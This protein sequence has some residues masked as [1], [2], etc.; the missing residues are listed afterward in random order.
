MTTRMRN[1]EGSPDDQMTNAAGEV[2]SL[3]F[4]LPRDRARQS[5]RS[6]RAKANHSSLRPRFASLRTIRH[7]SFVISSLYPSAA[8]RIAATSMKLLFTFFARFHVLRRENSNQK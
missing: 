8:N 1:V 4:R 5:L 3:E 2:S 7:L 6:S